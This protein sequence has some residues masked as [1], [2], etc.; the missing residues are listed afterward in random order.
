MA[1]NNP[2]GE[3]LRRVRERAEQILET[4]LSA[5]WVGQRSRVI[6]RLLRIDKPRLQDVRDLLPQSENPAFR[7]GFERVLAEVTAITVDAEIQRIRPNVIGIARPVREPVGIGP[8]PVNKPVAISLERPRTTEFIRDRLASS[9]RRVVR[10]NAVTRRAIRE[11]LRIGIERGYSKDQMARGVPA[12]DYR[13]I[14]AVVEE[15]YKN[16]AR[17]IARTEVATITN[18]ASVQAFRELGYRRV[19]CYD[20]ADCGLKGHKHPIKP[21]G[22]LFN[23]NAAYIYAISHPQCRRRWFPEATED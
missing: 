9:A 14:G 15:T 21:A 22:K 19:R 20:S 10:I 1:L 3:F 2:Q 18:R 17:T 13:G 5:W 4:F 23:I 16:R 12:D 11:Q 7:V 8:R 6:D